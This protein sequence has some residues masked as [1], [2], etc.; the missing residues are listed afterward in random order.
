MQGSFHARTSLAHRAGRTKSR[1]CRFRGEPVG[2]RRRIAALRQPEREVDPRALHRRHVDRAQR[3]RHRHAIGD[4][5][6]VPDGRLRVEDARLRESLPGASPIDAHR[7]RQP[8]V[9]VVAEPVGLEHDVDEPVAQRLAHPR[10]EAVLAV[11]GIEQH[12][13]VEPRRSRATSRACDTR[14]S[15]RPRRGASPA[16]RHR[17]SPSTTRSSAS[18]DG[19]VIGLCFSRGRIGAMNIAL[20]PLSANC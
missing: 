12:D 13:G 6:V 7:A 4:E 20:M 19:H 16:S 1:N 5:R 8:A 9:H 2:G 10:R 3:H 18:S 14:P 15:A 17:R 11:H